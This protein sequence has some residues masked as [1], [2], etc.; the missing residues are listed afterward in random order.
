[1]NPFH[2]NPQ[3]AHNAETIWAWV[4]ALRPKPKYPA[5]VQEVLISRH[6]ESNFA[7][8]LTYKEKYNE[9]LELREGVIVTVLEN[10]CCLLGVGDG[11]ILDFQKNLPTASISFHSVQPD[12][13][14]DIRTGLHRT[15][16]GLHKVL[17]R[18]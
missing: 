11:V 15:A 9:Q 1:M 4:H 6:E 2:T 5:I 8:D 12:P 3:I 16:A 17:W 14:I 7:H 10:K 18:Y 13:S